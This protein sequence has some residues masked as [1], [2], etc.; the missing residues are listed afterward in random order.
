MI[1]SINTGKKHLKK[2]NPI[3]N[4]NSKQTRN[5]RR[6]PQ[7]DKRHLTKPVPNIIL[8]DERHFSLAIKN[9]AKMSILTSI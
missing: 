4:K 9:K 7:S 5:R 8:S 3:P 1:I 2:F 6:L